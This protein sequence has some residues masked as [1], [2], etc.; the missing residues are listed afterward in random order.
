[1]NVR[2]LVAA[3]ALLASGA[4]AAFGCAT[5]PAFA[6]VPNDTPQAC[7]S[8]KQS[9]AALLARLPERALEA[10]FRTELPESTLGSAP[11]NGPVLEVH[12]QALALDGR[13]LDAAAWAS[14]AR[15][16]PAASTLYV[17]AAPD[18][19]IHALRM[20]LAPV[21][22]AVT[23]K[24]LVRV[25]SPG[26]LPNEPGTPA[27]AQAIAARLLVVHDPADRKTLADE[28][29]AEFT[30]CAALTAAVRS[31]PAASS[32]ERW[33]AL[34]AA[35]TPAVSGCGC[36][37]LDAPALRALVT[38]EQRANTATL[39][40]LPL[41]FVRDQRCEASMGLR[42]I[43]RLLEQIERFDADYAG[44]FSDDAVRFEQVVTSDR[45]LVQF[46]DAL[47]GETLAALERARGTLYFHAVGGTECQAWSLSPLSPGA[48]LGTLRRVKGGP[49]LAFHYA[50]ASEE[51]SLFGPASDDPKSKPTD[52]RE[53]ACRANYKL[54][55]I[56]PD[57][58]Q[59]ESGRFY[60]TEA[61]CRA[62][63]DPT[64]IDGCIATL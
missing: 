4:L 53:W 52:L 11:G 55:G 12:E 60:F 8:R 56:E 34:R 2:R 21:P 22:A 39:G 16:L 3:T 5:R 50:Q 48:P 25:S 13:A 36:G 40:A 62:A 28:G 35:L 63:N 29:Y 49:P 20:A 6:P 7:E 19:T 15:E 37:S 18:V 27:R 14:Q 44:S 57:W 51:I 31:V 33:P 30:N 59:L 46:C 54:V 32:R 47:P 45:L 26:T 1:M 17:A 64:A 23:P 58:I 41:G 61:G 10:D 42:S 38:A 9:L 24:L 43:K